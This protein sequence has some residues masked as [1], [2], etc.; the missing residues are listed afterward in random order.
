MHVSGWNRILVE[1]PAGKDLSGAPAQHL[2]SGSTS[3]TEIIDNVY[4]SNLGLQISKDGD[5]T[6]FQAVSSSV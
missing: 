1:K 5:N 2:A 4:V 3:Y 6:T